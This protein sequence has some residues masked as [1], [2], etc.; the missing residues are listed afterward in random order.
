[1]I[2]YIKYRMIT[3]LGQREFYDEFST[4]ESRWQWYQTICGAGY[5]LIEFGQRS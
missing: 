2:Y 4:I 1:M 3:G 5:E